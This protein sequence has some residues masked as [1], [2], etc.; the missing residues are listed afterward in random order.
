MLCRSRGSRAYQGA[1]EPH[2]SGKQAR[3]GHPARFKSSRP[4]DAKWPWRVAISILL[5]LLRPKHGL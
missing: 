3:R 2:V 1:N 4:K 5:E